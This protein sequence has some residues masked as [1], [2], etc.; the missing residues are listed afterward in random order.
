MFGSVE[1]ARSV[2]AAEARLCT[3]IAR[4]VAARRPTE[5]VLVEEI[6]GGVATYGGPDSPINKM[7]GLGFAGDLDESQLAR[8][9][10]AFAERHARLQAEV[11][12]LAEPAVHRT[13]M[14]RGYV[15][16]GFEHVLGRPL[17]AGGCQAP[18]LESIRIEPMRRED[19]SRWMDVTI[20]AFEHPDAEGVGGDQVPPRAALERIISDM[21]AIESLR[22]YSAHLDDHF[23]GGASLRIDGE[24]AQ[25]CGAATLPRFRR[26]GI[27]TVLLRARL[28]DA[29]SA[30]CELAV[31]TTA[32]GSKSQ[33]HMQRYGFTLLYGRALLVKGPGH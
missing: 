24:I 9:E 7:V 32:P 16:E 10:T 30:G 33:Q 28:A 2:D 17:T 31:V 26:R 19:L 18:S 20:T 25:L 13:L 15:L 8:I 12:T 5:R 27:Q 11:A 14:R 4:A 1:L 29:L 22:R 23:A 3:E 21:T 6:G